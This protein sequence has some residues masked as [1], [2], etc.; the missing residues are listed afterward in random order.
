MTESG[1]KVLLMLVDGKNYNEI[2]RE[3]G[4]TRQWA[5]ECAKKAI[6][7]TRNYDKYHY[8][9]IAQFIADNSYTITGFAKKVNI[10]YPTLVNMLKM[11]ATPSW[12][13]IAKL[14]EFTGLAVEVLMYDDK[15]KPVEQE[16]D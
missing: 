15:T 3:L 1:K 7:R 14:A 9:N 8:P 6:G 10:A 16:N 13:T 11:G 2:A 5:H 12:K 4:T